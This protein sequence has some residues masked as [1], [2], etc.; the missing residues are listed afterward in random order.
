MRTCLLLLIAAAS[1]ACADNAPLMPL[2]SDALLAKG[3]NGGGGGGTDSRA[4][5]YFHRT[6]SDGVTATRLY[7][8]GR[9][10]DGTSLADASTEPSAY[11]GEAQCGARGT[12]A[13]YS[14]PSR[15]SGNAFFA[16]QGGSTALCQGVARTLRVDIG[17][18]VEVKWTTTVPGIMQLAVGGSAVQDLMFGPN[19]VIPN[20]ARLV[21]SAAVVSSGVRVTRLAGDEAGS[22]GEWTVESEGTHVAGCYNFTR[23]NQL[24]HTGPDYYLPFRARVVE[25]LR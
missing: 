2:P 24:S 17:T 1:I 23:G 8:D 11:D 12:I 18:V 22:P 7:G 6:L 19:V 4:Q 5:W 10:L 13:W 16:P 14:D 9:A 20:C 3:G 25:V 21:Y 15:A